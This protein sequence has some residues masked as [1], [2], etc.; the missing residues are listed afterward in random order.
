MT[1]C[2]K[3]SRPVTDPKSE[4]LNFADDFTRLGLFQRQFGEELKMWERRVE[5]GW[6]LFVFRKVRYRRKTPP[7]NKFTEWSLYLD[8][9]EAT[10]TLCRY[11]TQGYREIIAETERVIEQC[12]GKH[13]SE[14]VP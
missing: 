9:A 3:R 6:N 5:P 14:F 12:A 1:D 10:I 4:L 13:V 8:W 2:F 11:D 7:G